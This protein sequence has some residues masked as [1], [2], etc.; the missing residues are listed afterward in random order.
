MSFNRRQFLHGAGAALALPWLESIPARATETGKLATAAAA[1]ANKPPV[2]LAEIFFSNGVETSHWWANGA[3]SSMEL[4]KGLEPLLPYRED[5]NFLR[6][7][8]NKQAAEHNAAHRGR[9]TNLLSGAWVPNDRTE[10]KVGN[11]DAVLDGK[12]DEFI[13]AYLL[14]EATARETMSTALSS[15]ETAEKNK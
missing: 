4:G 5:F 1:A 12:I 15:A 8:Y 2:R 11:V 6:G 13:S 7:L 10:I 9:V 3:G 14:S